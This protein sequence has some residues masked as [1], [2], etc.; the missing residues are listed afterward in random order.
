MKKGFKNANSKKSL[1]IVM[2]FALTILFLM[3]SLPMTTFAETVNTAA[4][5]QAI[6]A[7]IDAMLA[8]ERILGEVVF[9]MKDGITLEQAS[10]AL[11]VIGIPNDF[12]DTSV[13]KYRSDL[14]TVVVFDKLWF[15]IS[16]SENII[17]QTMYKLMQCEEVELA[18]PQLIYSI[19]ATAEDFAEADRIIAAESA[20][21]PDAPDNDTTQWAMEKMGVASAWGYGFKGKDSI[22]IGLLDTGYTPH[23]DMSN[24]DTTDSK[25]FTRRK[26]TDDPSEYEYYETNDITDQDSH[27]TFMAGVIGASLNGEGVTGICQNVTI[28][29]IKITYTGDDGDDYTDSELMGRGVGYAKQIGVDIINL[30]FSLG[31][32]AHS[33]IKA[34]DFPGLMVF[35]AGNDG[36]EVGVNENCM[37]F[38][39]EEANWIV[40]GNS[41]STDSPKN[42]S[43]YSQYYVDLFAPGSNIT[44][45]KNDGVGYRTTSGTSISAPYV[46]AAA[47]LIMSHATHLTVLEVKQLLLD[48]VDPIEALEDKCVTGGRLAVDKAV[49][50]LYDAS[51]PAF[52]N[53]D[54]NGS[55][56]IDAIDY[57]IIKRTALGTYTPSLNERSGADADGNGQIDVLDYMMV[58]RHYLR[59]FYIP[60]V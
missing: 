54:S 21:A 48:T 43:N 2:I 25:C 35:A 18:I 56:N 39:P 28:V 29:P 11:G 44:S 36:V 37:G 10:I 13:Y 49:S 42:N 12:N 40:V 9:Y 7:E 15:T 57:M 60:P 33:Q 32:C 45:L 46:A 16:V 19:A 31:T 50:A 38:V 47:A 52:S 4:E 20:A 14:D 41:T 24:V 34:H 22:K 30:S 23:V 17:A 1:R 5:E 58:K 6:L 59:S 8:K 27:G 26:K 53:G 51:R 3:T 55:G